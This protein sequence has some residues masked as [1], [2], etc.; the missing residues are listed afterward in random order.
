MADSCDLPLRGTGRFPTTRLG[1]VFAAAARDGR[2]ASGEAMET[3]CRLYWYPLYAFIRRQGN[4]VEEAQDLTQAFI[5][6]LLEKN[7]LRRFRQERGRFRT[8]LLTCLKHFLANEREF[9]RA[10]RRGGGAPH[11]PF[12]LGVGTAESRYRLEGRDAL[13]PERI[14]EKRWALEVLDQAATRLREEFVRADK[15]EHFDRFRAY[16]TGADARTPYRQL[17]LEAGMTEGAVRVAIH[18]LRQ[19][20]HQ[21]L[22]EVIALT[23]RDPN[24]VGAEV[25]HLIAAIRGCL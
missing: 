24:E 12:D 18:R 1:L 9:R 5:V 17:A 14:F 15:S 7:T 10:A 25:R 21:A 22:R 4:S 20:Y 3:L 13:T 23:V 11:V 8:F 2:D 6:Y 16:L 19:R